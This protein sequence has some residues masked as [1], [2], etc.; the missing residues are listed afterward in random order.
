MITE[1]TEKHRLGETYA[2][3]AIDME[4]FAV[5]DFFQA[6]GIPVAILRVISDDVNQ[7]LPDLSDVFD[8][9][10]NLKSLELAK[11]M[12]QRPWGAIQLIRSSLIALKKLEQLAT[13]ISEQ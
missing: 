2:V 8:S 9:E 7:T 3:V 6:K 4:S 10:G 12:V 1:K 5:L 11:K 13:M